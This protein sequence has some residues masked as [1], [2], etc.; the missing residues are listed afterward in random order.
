MA[1][2]LKIFASWFLGS[3]AVGIGFLFLFN[4]LAGLAS[5]VV[6]VTALSMSVA[7]LVHMIMRRHGFGF[8]RIMATLLAGLVVMF[9]A[10]ASTGLFNFT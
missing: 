6:V 1:G 3:A 5:L 4:P 10:A 2:Q 7:P 8:G 9:F